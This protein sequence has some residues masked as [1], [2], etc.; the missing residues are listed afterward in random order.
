VSIFLL[1]MTLLI[2]GLVKKKVQI[3]KIFKI[4]IIIIL[5]L[6]SCIIFMD[7]LYFQ[8]SSSFIFTKTTN[9]SQEN[10]GGLQ[11]Y[12]SIDSEEFVKKYGTNSKRK[13]NALFDYYNL[14]DNLVIATNKDRQ[15]IRIIK[16]NESDRDIKTSKGIGLESSVEEVIEA[17]GKNYYKR[18]SDFGIPVIGYIDKAKNIT[19]EFFYYEDKVEEIRYDITSME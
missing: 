18:V 2:M 19:I 17:Y 5:F 9:L 4:V 6:I 13:D 3:K 16:D 10:I 8:R 7:Y 12:Q 15:I 14:S 1:A 11:L